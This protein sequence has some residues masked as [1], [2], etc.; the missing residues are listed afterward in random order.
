MGMG[1]GGKERGGSEKTGE[2][3]QEGIRDKGALK[4]R[5]EESIQRKFGSD[6]G[7]R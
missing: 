1:K 6:L 5:G 2:W 7:V 3:E 4:G